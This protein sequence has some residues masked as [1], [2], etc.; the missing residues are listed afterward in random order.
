MAVGRLAAGERQRLQ[1]R[2]HLHGRRRRALLRASSGFTADCICGAVDGVLFYALGVCG[3]PVSA[4]AAL[5]VFGAR[6]S[7]TLALLPLCMWGPAAR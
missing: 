6:R 4:A 5:G 7:S 3:T 1:R 2:L